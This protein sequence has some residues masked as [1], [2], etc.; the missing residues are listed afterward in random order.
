MPYADTIT[1]LDLCS[2]CGTQLSNSSKRTPNDTFLVEC[3]SCGTYEIS[4]ECLMFTDM[5]TRLK[6]RSPILSKFVS[7]EN[8]KGV[9]WPMIQTS[10]L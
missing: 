7:D 8:V 9:R 4:E 5:K 2:L 6:E 10:M 1:V 3:S